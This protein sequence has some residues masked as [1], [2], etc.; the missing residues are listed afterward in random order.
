MG[1]SLFCLS[2]AYLLLGLNFLRGLVFT[3]TGLV[4]VYMHLFSVGLF[5]LKDWLFLFLCHCK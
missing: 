1:F 3:V 2:G 5:P 4:G